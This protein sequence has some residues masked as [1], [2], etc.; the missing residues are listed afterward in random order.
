MWGAEV[1]FF[2][3]I[4]Y[5]DAIKWN[6]RNVQKQSVFAQPVTYLEMNKA[7]IPV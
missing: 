1:Q 4:D 7:I 2:V 5:R 3:T 6:L